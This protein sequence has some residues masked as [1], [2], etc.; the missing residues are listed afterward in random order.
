[1][2][3]IRTVVKIGGREYTMVGDKPEEYIHRVAIFV[4]KKMQ[5]IEDGGTGNMSTT[6]LAVLTAV[7]IADE[8]LS[9]ADETEE[10]KAKIDELSAEVERLQSENVRL[11]EKLKDKKSIPVNQI[12]MFT[13]K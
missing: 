3:K 5:E 9:H 6:M 1:M 7:N 10:L 11:F 13:K 4:D 12:P 8:Y 2:Q